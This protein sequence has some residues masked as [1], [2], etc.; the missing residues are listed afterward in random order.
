ML[1]EIFVLQLVTVKMNSHGMLPQENKN[2]ILE[3]RYFSICNDREVCLGKDG[4]HADIQCIK[5]NGICF[6]PTVGPGNFLGTFN[7]RH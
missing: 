4:N 6:I 2:S 5:V 7:S 1:E 3:N